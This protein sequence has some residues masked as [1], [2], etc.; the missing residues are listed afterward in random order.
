[1]LIAYLTVAPPL[2]VPC[3]EEANVNASG[4]IDLSDLSAMIAFI[5]AGTYTLPWCP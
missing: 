1:L 2:L 4:S 5:T 3:E